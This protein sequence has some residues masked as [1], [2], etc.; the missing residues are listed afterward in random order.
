MG[1]AAPANVA[2]SLEKSPEVAP[3]DVKMRPVEIDPLLAD[4]PREIVAEFARRCLQYPEVSEDQAF[5]NPVWKAGKRTFACAHH[6]NE[7]L[8]LQ[9]WVGVEQQAML[10]EDPRYMIPMYVGHNGWIDL[11]VGDHVDWNEVSGLLDTS[12]RHFALKRMLKALDEA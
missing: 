7:R 10:T 6:N 12:Y 8:Y 4:G 1:N 9:L 5:G 3:P 2:A 11:D